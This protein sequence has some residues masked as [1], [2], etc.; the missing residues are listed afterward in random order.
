MTTAA[1]EFKINQLPMF[2]SPVDST[3]SINVTLNAKNELV[4]DPV[5]SFES[6]KLVDPEGHGL[7]LQI[8]GFSTIKSFL[9]IAISGKNDMFT[10]T[11]K[12]DSIT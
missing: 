4:E 2:V 8:M 3:F 1:K 12:R 9:T 5:Y 6:P 10:L 7:K 11:F